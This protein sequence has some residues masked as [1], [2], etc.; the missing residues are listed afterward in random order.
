[1]NI[2]R[3]FYIDKLLTI[4]GFERIDKSIDFPNRLFKFKENDRKLNHIQ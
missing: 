3:D 4:E 2:K 1:M